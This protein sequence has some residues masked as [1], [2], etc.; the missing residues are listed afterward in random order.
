MSRSASKNVTP[1][2][3][4]KP[5]A[6]VRSAGLAALSTLTLV[7]WLPAAAADGCTVMLCLAAPNWRDIAECVPPVRQ[8]M[9]DLARGKPFPSCEMTGAGNSARH[10]WSATPEF[11]PPQYTRESE[12]E[13]TKVY[14][15]DYSGA[16]TVTIDGK[17]FTRTWWSGSGDTVTQ[18]SSTAKS[19]LGTWDRRYDAEYAAWLAAR[20]MPVESY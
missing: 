3:V 2:G 8:V 20:P 1:T 10:A 5:T 13:G 7:P 14:T 19:Q 15:C 6:V 18:F 16:I 4:R 11:C 9:R 17:R 12:L